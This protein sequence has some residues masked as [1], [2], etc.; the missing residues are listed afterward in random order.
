MRQHGGV[1]FD[2]PYLTARE[3]EV[4]CYASV[5]YTSK[6]I[7]ALLNISIQ[8]VKNHFSNLCAKLRARNRTHAVALMMRSMIEHE[9][10]L[11]V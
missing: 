2:S 7:A 1:Y 5:G 9:S 8:T 3:R 4:I 10:R 11:H 6:E